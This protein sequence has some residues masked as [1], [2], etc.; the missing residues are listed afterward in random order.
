MQQENVASRDSK[1]AVFSEP[2]SYSAASLWDLRGGWVHCLEEAVHDWVLEDDKS[3]PSREDRDGM[4]ED[5]HPSDFPL[6]DISNELVS[7]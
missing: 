3:W 7:T 6:S 1:L 2:H 4:G 5:F